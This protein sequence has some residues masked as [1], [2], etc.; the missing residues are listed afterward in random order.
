MVTKTKKQKQ[1]AKSNPSRRY[2]GKPGGVIQ[3]RVQ[4]AGPQRFGVVAVDCAKKRSK[5]FLC[6]FYGRVIVEPT[7]VEHNAGSLKV[8][9]LQ[10]Q[11]ACQAEGLVDMIAAVEMT[12]VYHQ[13]VQAA[14]RKAGFDTRTVHPFASS[15][16]RRPL[17]PDQKTDN[18]DL[19]AIFHAAINGYGLAL[20]EVDSVY[21]S[22]QRLA[23]HRRNL[24][25]QK[26]RLQIQIRALMHQTIPGYA[27]LFEE[28]K[29]F[30]RSIAI[31]IAKRFSSASSIKRAGSGGIAKDLKSQKIRFQIQT[32]D[33]IVAWS[34]TAAD[35]DPLAELLTQQWQQLVQIHD[36]MNTQVEQTEREMASGRGSWTDRALRFGR[37]HQ[38]SGRTLSVSIP[39]RRSRS[40][41]QRS[42]KLQP[43]FASRVHS[44]CQESHQMSF[45]LSRVGGTLENA[46]GCHRRSA[47]PHRQ[48]GQSNGLSARQRSASMARQRD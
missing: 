37:R 1:S 36:L 8:M 22:L 6:D 17:H 41:R 25:K 38:R 35:P 24:V 29:L 20:L 12:G 31:T 34:A 42:Q 30:S 5:W 44:G 13:P 40:K 10:I 3:Q 46:K 27:D 18:N 16:Y 28:D 21:L 43:T 32:I 33:R 26:A 48:S 14:L 4:Q 19:E 11:D 2:V 39:K 23:R 47:M 45:V 7:P 15:H 9:A